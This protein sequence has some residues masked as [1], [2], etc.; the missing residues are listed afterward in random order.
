MDWVQMIKFTVSILLLMFILY[1]STRVFCGYWLFTSEAGAR[2]FITA[3]IAVL[4]I[5][6]FES[7]INIGISG[8]GFVITFFIM[9]VATRFIIVEDTASDRDW[10]DAILI[11]V[12]SLIII[13]VVNIIVPILPLL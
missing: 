6:A 2:L 9:M 5:P 7:V 3:L 12:L 11:T 13:Y 1:I 10:V 4:L 8:M